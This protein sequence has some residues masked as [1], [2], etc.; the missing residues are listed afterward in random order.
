MTTTL[1][2]DVVVLHAGSAGSVLRAGSMHLHRRHPAGECNT[3][4]RHDR[5]PSI[6]RR[7]THTSLP[8]LLVMMAM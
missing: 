8:L 6:L 4:H 5:P 1:C 7:H 3:P 2:G